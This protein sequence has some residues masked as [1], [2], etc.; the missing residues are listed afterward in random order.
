MIDLKAG[1]MLDSGACHAITVNPTSGIVSICPAGRTL[2][3]LGLSQR[4]RE[5]TARRS[6]KATNGER[7]AWLSG[8]IM[9]SFRRLSAIAATILRV[10]IQSIYS[11]ATTA[12]TTEIA[13]TRADQLDSMVRA[14]AKQSSQ[15]K[16]LCIFADVMRLVASL[17]ESWRSS[18]APAKEQSKTSSKDADGHIFL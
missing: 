15:P 13:R 8:C 6:T 5:A 7:I 12:R 10:A 16:T 9:G 2:V 11:L 14:T 18:T 1:T 3:G 4:A 17:N